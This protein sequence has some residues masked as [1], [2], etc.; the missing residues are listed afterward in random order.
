MFSNEWNGDAF[1]SILNIQSPTPISPFWLYFSVWVGGWVSGVEKITTQIAKSGIKHRWFSR[2][3]I[4][5]NYS[6]ADKHQ[7]C[8]KIRSPHRCQASPL[9]PWILP[10]AGALWDLQPKAS[11]LATGT[12]Q[13]QDSCPMALKLKPRV[14]GL[15]CHSGW[16]LHQGAGA[17]RSEE[18]LFKFCISHTRVWSFLKWQTWFLSKLSSPFILTLFMFSFTVLEQG[19]A[20]FCCQGPYVDGAKKVIQAFP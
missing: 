1:P 14:C 3:N 6:P 17:P 7:L 4:N 2:L 18:W 12:I 11:L 8:L 20:T 13:A 10:S 9:S 15:C 19:K 16:E 5:T